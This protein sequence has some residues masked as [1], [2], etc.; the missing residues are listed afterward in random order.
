M[1]NQ[2][3]YDTNTIED[4]EDTQEGKHLIFSLGKEEYGIEIRNVTEIIGIQTI[5]DLPGVP[6]YVKGVINLRGKVIPIIDARLRFGFEEREYDERTCIIVVNISNMAVGLIVDSVSEVLDI[7]SKDI[8]PLA[9]LSQS[10]SNYI[11]GF[12][13][14]NAE[15][16]ILL[17][18]NKLLNVEQFGG[19]TQTTKE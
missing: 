19:L 13:K 18:I 15:V 8:E 17:D 3:Q 12:G 6:H 10:T 4:E 16:K 5:T 14:V 7:S 2:E 9:R 1:S 11:K